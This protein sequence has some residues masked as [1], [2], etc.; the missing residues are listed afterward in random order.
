LARQL[1]WG[2]AVIE[3]LWYLALVGG[4]FLLWV[5]VVALFTPRIDYKLHRRLDCDS[6]EFL[7][8]LHSTTHTSLHQDSRFDVLTNASQF[9]PAM[10]EAIHG[11]QAS[12]NM[13]CYCFCDDAIG[14]EFMLALIERA[15]TGVTVTLVVDALGSLGFGITA[16]RRMRRAGVRVQLYQHVTWYRLARLN[17]RTHRELLIVD[18][19]VAF[20]GGAGVGDQWA[21]GKRGKRPWRDTMARVTGPVV[22]AIQGVFAENWVECCGEILTGDEYFPKLQTTGDTMA[23]TVKSSP[24]DRATAARVTFQMLIEGATKSIRVTTP[25]FLPDQSMREAFKQTA[26]RGVRIDIIV[27]GSHTD[28]RWVRLVSR[29]KYRELLKE[30]IRIYEYRAGMIHAKILNVDDLWVVLGTTNF[31]N[32]SFEHN[33]EVNVAIRDEAMSARLKKDFHEDLR[34]CEEV[35]MS[36]WKRRSLFEKIVEPFCW[37]LERQ[38]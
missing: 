6:K 13:E 11:A 22:A 9:Y 24:S 2:G 26:R 8:T 28:Q 7:H 16:V 38:Q 10:L 37:L 29:R 5:V 36:T 27:P 4:L 19:N 31:D 3:Y 34:H 35:T 20:V 21:R 25:Y 1:R 30:G 15:R 23:I 12:I 32:R 17:N 33:D 18:G 14:R